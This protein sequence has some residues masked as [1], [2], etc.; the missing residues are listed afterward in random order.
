MVDFIEKLALEF[1]ALIGPPRLRD[2]RLV[3]SQGRV[4]SKCTL[5]SRAQMEGCTSPGPLIWLPR[6]LSLELKLQ[7]MVLRRLSVLVVRAGGLCVGF[8]DFV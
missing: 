3:L 7:K 1:R 5:G 4:A 2:Q 8:E 6:E